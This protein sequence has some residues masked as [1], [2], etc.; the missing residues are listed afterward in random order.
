MKIATVALALSAAVFGV[1]GAAI[2]LRS[3][4]AP[5]ERVRNDATRSV[6]L[7]NQIAPVLEHPRCMNCHTSTDFPRQGDDRHRHIMN[8]KRGPENMGAPGLE[9]STCHQKS[10]S[11]AGVPGNPVWH[12]APLSM[13]WEGRS[14][15]EICRSLLDPKRGAM[16]KTQLSHHMGEDPLVAWAWDPG[17]D[18]DGHPRNQP[19]IGHEAFGKLV[20]QWLESGAHCPA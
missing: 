18:V 2:Q 16:T 13:A 6:A 10:N 7:F 12:L 14:R 15:G 19:P 9:C 20:D 3:S 17:V 4:A 1:S 8:V 5:S 11:S